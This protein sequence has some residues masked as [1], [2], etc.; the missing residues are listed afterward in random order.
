[1]NRFVAILSCSAMLFLPAIGSAQDATLEVCNNGPVTVN[2]AYAARIQLFITGYKWKT[3][4]WYV[5]DPGKCGVVYDEDY[6]DA[7]PY[8]PQSGARVVFAAIVKDTWRVYHDNKVQKSGW[9]QSGTGQ[10]CVKLSS[11][12]GFEFNEPA[13]DPAANCT[14]GTL[15]PVAQ[16][17]LPDGPGKFTYTMDWDGETYSVAVGKIPASSSVARAK[18]TGPPADSGNSFSARF[19]RMIEQQQRDSAQ[20]AN[21]QSN[22]DEWDATAQ[23]AMLEW[24]QA[25]LPE[26]LDASTTEFEIYRSGPPQ[27]SQGLRMWTSSEQ[28]PPARGCW[29]VQ[30]DSTSTLSCAITVNPA[31]ERAYYSQLA[32]DFKATLPGDWSAVAG[33]VFGGSLPSTGFRS[34]TGAHCEIW[35]VE[36]EGG[37]YDVHF[38]IVSAPHA[39]RARK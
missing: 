15:V 24:V 35:L 3:T 26:Y 12:A 36:T 17:F 39:A 10:I 25:D 14:G 6:G 16:D 7:G 37:G 21:S 13:G 33:S 29:V 27:L 20:R 19:L 11:S 32:D 18:S 38:Q 8:T 9:M 31:Y 22:G 23:A 1:M 28:P 2:V 5:V 30:G 4:G 34:T